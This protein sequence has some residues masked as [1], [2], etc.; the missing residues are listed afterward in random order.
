M[1]Q[2]INPSPKS[3]NI[4]LT[5][6]N[7][8]KKNSSSLNRT[9]NKNKTTEN[10]RSRIIIEEDSEAGASDLDEIERN[11]KQKT[12]ENMTYAEILDVN[13]DLRQQIQN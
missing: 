10:T 12:E 6:K 11:L 5:G 3:N 7:K 4:P 13:G 9:K 2:P 8:K 1:I